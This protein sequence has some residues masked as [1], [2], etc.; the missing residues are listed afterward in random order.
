MP[1]YVDRT[2]YT[3]GFT[4]PWRRLLGFHAHYAGISPKTPHPAL[5]TGILVHEALDHYLK[6]GSV[7]IP[8]VTARLPPSHVWESDIIATAQSQVEALVLGWIRTTYPWFND[9]FDLVATEQEMTLALPHPEFSINWMAR[10]DLVA[11]NRKTGA[12]TVHDFKTTSSW[13]DRY[14]TEWGDSLQLMMNAHCTAQHYGEPVP[15]YYV[16]FLV[17]GSADYPT[18]LTH[19]W[20]RPASPPL[21]AEDW[22]IKKPYKRTGLPYERVLISKH[23]PLSAWVDSLPPDIISKYFIVGGPFLVNPYKIRLFTDGLIANEWWWQES[24][25]SYLSTCVTETGKDWDLDNP[26]TRSVLN[27]FFP[28]TFNC[29]TYNSRCSFYDVCL[30]PETKWQDRYELRTPHHPQEEIL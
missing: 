13:Q 24:L 9:N 27:R 19:A 18:P 16:H 3:A 5:L 22:Q 21:D 6:T 8:S 29:Y 11:R 7:F 10:P 15:H 25:G 23:R 14:L 2:R 28:R 12:L 26:D 30:K 1:W 20:L 17:K 4:C